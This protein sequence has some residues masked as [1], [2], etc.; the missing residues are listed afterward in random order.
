[1]KVL[2]FVNEEKFNNLCFELFN[3]MLYDNYTPDIIIGCKNG[4]SIVAQKIYDYF[5][6]INHNCIYDNVEVRHK[7]TNSFEKIKID[8]IFKYTPKFILNILRVVHIILYEFLYNHFNH[9]RE[10]TS[11][12][13]LSDDTI[14]FIK[15]GNKKIL[16]VDDA[17]DSGET[18]YI[19][20]EY[21]KT[22][23]DNNDIKYCV[24]TTTYKNPIIVPNYTV[25]NRIILRF[26]WAFDAYK[27]I[28]K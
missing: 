4:G 8:R 16:V 13:N 21:L 19:I 25:Y 3:S 26:P 27:F 2:N 17:I 7:S 23:N 1:M 22:L 24:C 28:D 10:Y 20:R 11:Y 18:M 14:S 9:L 15:E 5:K 12:F 6:I